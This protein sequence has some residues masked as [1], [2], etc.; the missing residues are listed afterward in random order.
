MY[1]KLRIDFAQHMHRIWHHFKFENLAGQLFR[2]LINDLFQTFIYTPY[3]HLAAIL[4][5]KNNIVFAGVYN[6]TL[7]LDVLFIAHVFYYTVLCY[8]MSR[9]ALY[10]PIAKP[11]GFT[12]HFGKNCWIDVNF[13]VDNFK[14][15]TF[16]RHLHQVFT[17]IMK[18][19][20]YS[21]NCHF[22]YRVN[23]ITSKVW[24]KDF[25]T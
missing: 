4:W 6:M 15:R 21:P 10:I 18:I 13:K 19:T 8:I 16:K 12:P 2:H 22:S 23:I 20:L 1:P 17:N 9:S 11:R 24:L 25:H 5:A 14:P 7:A 3:E